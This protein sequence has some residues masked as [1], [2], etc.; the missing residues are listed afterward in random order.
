MNQISNKDM[1][2][3]EFRMHSIAIGHLAIRYTLQY[4]SSKNILW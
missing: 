4:P 2:L 3:I 1:E